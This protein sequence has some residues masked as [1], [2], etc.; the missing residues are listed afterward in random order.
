MVTSRRQF[1]ERSAL[2]G[3]A[4]PDRLEGVKGLT[5]TNVRVN[6]QLKNEVIDR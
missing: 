1:L 2:V 4:Q 6:G 3:V 5:L